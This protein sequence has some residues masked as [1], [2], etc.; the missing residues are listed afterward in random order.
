MAGE[1]NIQA[2]RVLKAMQR[3]DSEAATL[4]AATADYSNAGPPNWDRN[5]WEAFKSQYGF[6]PYRMQNGTQMLPE[7]FIGCP[8]W[9]YELMGL[10]V[11]PVGFRPP[12]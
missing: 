10:R 4:G 5:A 11:P 8:A 6:Y 9:A 7:N 1:R 3:Q 12:S 2:L